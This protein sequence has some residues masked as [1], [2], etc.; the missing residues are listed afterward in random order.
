MK[1]EQTAEGLPT[2]VRTTLQRV[3]AA[4]RLQ[5]NAFGDLVED[6]LAEAKAGTET[7]AALLRL[8]AHIDQQGEE[9]QQQL[10]HTLTR[11]EGDWQGRA[12]M[13]EAAWSQLERAA[14]TAGQELVMRSHSSE[15]CTK[16]CTN[17]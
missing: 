2:E 13:L 10:Q 1:L 15:S 6:C 5:L 17:A 14:Y 7:R 8:I 9:M 3:I 12:A 4:M 16:P 11:R